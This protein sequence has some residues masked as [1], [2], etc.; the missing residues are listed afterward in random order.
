MSV[1]EKKRKLTY[2]D[3][4][5]TPEDGK[6]YEIIDGKLY[7]SPAPRVRHQVVVGELHANLYNF[8]K[9]H[10]VGRVYLGP[11]DV[12]LSLHDVVEPD[13]LFVARGHEEIL[14]ELNLQGPPDL[15]VEVLSPSNRRHDEVR[16]W[17]LYERSG[18]REYW[19]VDAAKGRIRI[20]RQTTGSTFGPAV[21]IS[22]ATGD[23]LTTP[24][25]PGLSLPL[26]DIFARVLPDLG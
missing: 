7:V 4:A 23:A 13:L 14:T 9:G 21:E 5:N 24:L 17:R 20:F 10:P 8:L 1:H 26:A 2:E 6:R 16:K 11:C 18:V 12:L 15:V 19:I 3:L 25:M 22:A